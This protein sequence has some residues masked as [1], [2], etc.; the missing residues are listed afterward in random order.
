M[1]LYLL[2]F[3]GFNNPHLKNNAYTNN[4]YVQLIINICT[5]HTFFH[6]SKLKYTTYTRTLTKKLHTKL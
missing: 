6:F 1:T 5:V 4:I 3:S 2:Y